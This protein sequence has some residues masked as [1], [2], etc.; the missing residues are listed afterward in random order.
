[1]FS[2]GTLLSG[3]QVKVPVAEATHYDDRDVQ[4]NNPAVRP[5]L[6]PKEIKVEKP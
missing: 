3:T 6:V 4:H 5:T 2:P 1:M